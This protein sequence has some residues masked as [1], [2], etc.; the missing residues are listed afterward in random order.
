MYHLKEL[1]FKLPESIKSLK[2]DTVNKS[3]DCLKMSSTCLH[4]YWCPYSAYLHT[5][6]T[7][8]SQSHYYCVGTSVIDLLNQRLSSGS[9]LTQNEVLHIFSDVTKAVARLHHRTKPIIHRDLK[10]C[11]Y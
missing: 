5:F 2:S 4:V 3:Y 10:V 8:T 9:R 11:L 1:T 6:E 7:V